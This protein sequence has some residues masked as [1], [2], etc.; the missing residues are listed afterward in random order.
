MTDGENDTGTGQ[1][2]TKEQKRSPCFV[3]SGGYRYF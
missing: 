3:C 1:A 2:E